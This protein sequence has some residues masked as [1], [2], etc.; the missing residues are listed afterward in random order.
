MSMFKKLLVLT[1]VFVGAI[2][3]VG[4]KDDTTDLTDLEALA[5]AMD[6]QVLP[7]EASTSLTFPN[8][9]LHSVE[10]TWTSSNTD[11]IA[12]D[13]TVTRPL[14]TE[15]DK[16]VTITAYLE[17]GGETLTKTFTVTVLK[18]AYSDADAVAEAKAVLLLSVSD[19]VTSDIVLPTTALTATLTWSSSN[20]AIV[21]N[22]G[23]ITRPAIGEG[24][25]T[26]TLTATI[27]KGTESL[28]KAFDVI[29]KE[30]DPSNAYASIAD[31]HDSLLGD[32]VE[33]QGIVTSTFDGGYFLT[34][35]TYALGVYNV[36]STLD[37]VVGDEVFVKG[38]YAMYNTLYQIN[39]VTE[40]TIISS[41]NATLL[42][43]VVKTVAEMLALDSSD[44]LIHG[45]PYTVT[46]TLIEAGEY[47]NLF[48][49]DGTNDL[50]IYYYSLEASL[51]AL[52]VELGKEVTITVVYYTDHG[53]NG[54]MVSF[55]GGAADIVISE[56][57]DVDALA[58]DIENAGLLLPA[59]TVGDIV[60]PTEGANGSLFTD[61][62][63]DDLAVMLSDGTFVARGAETLVVTFTATATKGV[64]TGTATIEVIVP[65]LST[66]GEVLGMSYGDYFE[67]AG[68]VYEESHYG[69]YI[70]LNGE[71]I[72][73]YDNSFLDDIAPGDEITVLG[74]RGEYSGLVQV[75][76]VSY[77][78]G[79]TGNTLPD[80]IVTTVAALQRDLVPRGTIA[81]VTATVSIEGTYGDVFLTD[82]AGGKVKVYYRSN[83]AD[84][85]E[86]AGQ[87]ITLNV[88]GY[89]NQVVLFNGVA[90]DVVV[91]T[92]F[93]ISQL[94][95]ATGDMI[96][97]GDIDT[98]EFDLVLPLINE[99]ADAT[100]T[101]STSN[102]DVI[103]AEGVVTRVPGEDVYVTL[104]AAIKVGTFNVAFI[105]AFNITVLDANGLPSNTVA[106]VLAMSD[107]ENVLVEGVVTGFYDNGYGT[108]DPMIQDTDGTAIYVN[109]GLD[110]E[111]GDLVKIRGDLFTYIDGWGA[112]QRRLEDATLVEIISSGNTVFVHDTY[113]AETVFTAYPETSSLRVTLTDVEIILMDDGYGYTFI[114]TGVTT[115]TGE[116][117]I[118]AI[119]FKAPAYFQD[120]YIVGSILPT[121][122]FN[123]IDINYD[124]LRVDTVE[125]PVL[126]EAQNM[127][128]AKGALDIPATAAADLTL[129]I[130]FPNFN[131]S[132]VWASSDE[133]VISTDGVVT[134]PDI[135]A[136]DATVTLT[137]TV[138][139]G[140]LVEDVVFVV[141]VAELPT[142]DLFIS[143]YIEGG[144]Y[145]KVIEIYNPTDASVDLSIYSLKLG[146]N[147][148]DFNNTLDLVGTLLPGE[149]YVVVHPSSIQAILDLA[150]LIDDSSV[151]N[152]NGDDAI[153]L[154][155]DDVLI[156][157]FGLEGYDPGSY[158]TVGDDTTQNHTLIRVPGVVCGT[159]VWDPAEWIAFDQDTI[160]DL[161]TH[162]P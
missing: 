59:I 76:V 162:T 33:F 101:W 116:D 11:V 92:G 151:I 91:E 35:G 31:L 71:Y 46:G 156:D 50:L 62:V 14:F 148:A 34:D 104:E 2:G 21:A 68:V 111:I 124:N 146:S 65:I 16:V 149:T 118:S 125:Y 127:L 39:Y 3:L 106:E 88:I 153:G 78:L 37:I 36:A 58:A 53:T 66:I 100:I 158:W 48:I 27:T 12:D 13:G 81:T 83:A 108:L 122:T 93:T 24:N 77:T 98:V 107:G 87:I 113:T 69:F 75:N 97:L 132:V 123:V 4:C 56:L 154:F 117:I 82:G 64:E 144:S 32:V 60:L 105:R 1:L 23:T 140:T 155:K 94:A 45:L 129:D 128:A 86:F 121:I 17:L 52:L 131:A 80:A 152:F 159:V 7:A 73:V 103:T 25:A 67:V 70:H 72:F 157:I 40:E 9:G 28:T 119:K 85:E 20:T 150:D 115:G 141:I 96:D 8:T 161:G 136:G 134:R 5:E 130:A 79:T 143:E 74:H 22:D 89:Q 90:A 55:D 147:G 18:A 112:I 63:S 99:L 51:D 41:D 145:N 49:S 26:V 38:E 30:E 135:G 95:Y 126:T 110:V 139:V 102:A 138:T 29:I 15:G 61:W 44:K 137:A 120:V 54:P 114:D 133:T 42:V 57:S 10:I 84:L 109:D 142:P 47:S 6:E 43:P 19:L 160:T